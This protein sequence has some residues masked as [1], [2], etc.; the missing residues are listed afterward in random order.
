MPGFAFT[1]FQLVTLLAIEGI[2]AAPGSPLRMLPD[3]PRASVPGE[4]DF[5]QLLELGFV[6][7]GEGQWVVNRALAAVLRAACSPDEVLD[8]AFSNLDLPGVTIV[9]QGDL[10]L[11]CTV[12]PGAAVT[13][14]YFPLTRD[15]V[16][17]R[18]MEMFSGTRP[19]D[20]PSGFHFVG[21]G[22]D[23]FALASALRRIRG[24]LRPCRVA[25]LPTIVAADARQPAL[26]AP[27]EAMVG[28]GTI[29]SFAADGAAVARA[30]NRLVAAGHLVVEGDLVTS[31]DAAATVLEAPLGPSIAISRAELEGG[32]V[33]RATMQVMRC[34]GHLLV[35]RRR[36]PAGAPV[37]FEW[38]EVD[39]VQ[40]RMLV[41][42]YLVAPAELDAM[43][44][45]EAA[46]STPPAP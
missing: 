33:R 46:A 19:L 4:P 23:V 2:A 36:T 7:A 24:D 39:R 3:L 27:I 31:S 22:D 13:K 20:P 28:L 29:A 21:S 18:V 34:G 41:A 26:V 42:S 8:I 30:L 32:E 35:F 45:L 15:A 6:R 10:R 12:G 9:R 25:D 37:A 1:E 16:F 44:N 14:I 11:E 38:V 17:A 40:L 43:L 5:D